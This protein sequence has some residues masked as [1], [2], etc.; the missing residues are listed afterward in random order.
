[1]R[2]ISSIAAMAAC[3]CFTSCQT[4]GWHEQTYEGYTLLQQKNGPTLG[5]SSKSG[6]KILFESGYAF[7]DLNRNGAIDIYEDWRHSFEERAKD[8][9]GQL[10]I[11]E[12][13]GLMLYSSHESIPSVS[14]NAS[15]YDGKPY[16]ESGAKPWML[17][18]KQKKFFKEDHLR[19]VLITTVESPEIAARWNNE[20]QAYVE[21]LGHGIPANNSSDPRHSARADAEFNAGGG[22]DISMWPSS[23]GLAATFSPQIVE[24]FGQIAAKEYRALGIATALSPQIDIATDPRWLRF[25]GTFG[26]DPQ[27]AA[28]MAEA[29]CNGFQTSSG[30]NEIA[31]GWGY[32]SVNTMVKHWP[33]G[34]AC[35]G[36]RDAHYGFGKYAVFPN[37]NLPL[38]KLPFTKGAFQLKGQTKKASAVMPYYTISNGQDDS[39]QVGNGFSQSIITHQLREEASYNGVVCTD[40]AITADVEHPGIHGGKP[41]GVETLTVTE[42][43]YK[44]IIAGVDQFGGNDDKKPILE[45]YQIGVKEHGE[46]W[47]MERMR[48]SAYRL[49]MN[50]FRTGLFEN[51]YIAPEYAAKTVGCSEYMKEGYEAQVKS[52]IL[53]KNSNRTLPIKD[54]KKVYIPSRHL[55]TYPNFWGGLN[56]ACDITPVS[57]EMAS[58]YFTLVDSPEK[59]DFAIVFIES[60]NSGYGYDMEE[61]KKGGTGY[62]P[63]SL[64]YNDYTAIHARAKSIAGGDPKEKF[65]NRSY[66]GKSTKTF[67]KNDMETVIATK[68][69]MGE[70]PVIVSL[71]IAN[72]TVLSEIEPYSDALLLTFDIQNQVVLDIVAGRYEPSG[73]LPMQMPADMET[74]EKQAEDTPHDMRCYQDADGHVYDFAYG[75]DWAGVI[76]DERVVKYKKN[77]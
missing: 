55:P 48:T 74:V 66:K 51:P 3:L 71:N 29:Y 67:N 49:L 35:E 39:E 19:H 62:K 73:L 58:K 47:M 14:W 16:A 60:P 33:G 43:H 9:A 4:K 75:L 68:K 69:A 6:V 52:T 18:D 37:S 76:N 77:K 70:H 5:Y 27:L 20:V 2:H 17:T 11:E 12:I 25:N 38:H 21:V 28:N 31:E 41:W 15:T 13:A 57:S 44:A 26:E 72:P 22:G 65:T 42:R 30:E 1:M 8:L 61:V 36:G 59:A 34:G 54:K 56:E 63:I 10:S 32:Q 7:K 46:E 64:Q 24:R 53:L 45:A 50:I 23:L 40:W